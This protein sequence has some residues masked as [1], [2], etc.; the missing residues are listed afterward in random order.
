[1]TAEPETARMRELVQWFRSIGCCPLC[2]AGMAIA[3][4]EHEAGRPRY[5]LGAGCGLKR[6]DAG[7]Q[8]RLTCRERA[9]ARAREIPQRMPPKQAAPPD[10]LA[11]RRARL[12]PKEATG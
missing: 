6:F 10:E 7:A 9:V 11:E 4:M 8:V 2:S 5:Q 1:M 12:V 3:W